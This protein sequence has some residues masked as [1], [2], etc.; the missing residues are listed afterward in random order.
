[1]TQTPPPEPPVREFA[2]RFGVWIVVLVALAAGIIFY[3]RYQS[4]VVPML[5]GGK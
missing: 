2:R 4:T 1:M 3:F 5:G